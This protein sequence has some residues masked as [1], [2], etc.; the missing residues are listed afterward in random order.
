MW[1]WW[2]RITVVLWCEP[3]L[4]HLRRP[5]LVVSAITTQTPTSVPE[6][7]VA[8]GNHIDAWNETGFYFHLWEKSSESDGRVGE[9]TEEMSPQVFTDRQRGWKG[10]SNCWKMEMKGEED[11]DKV[12]C[13]TVWRMNHLHPRSTETCPHLSRKIWR[14]MT[15]ISTDL[16]VNAQSERLKIM[17]EFY[18][19]RMTQPEKKRKVNV[20]KD[21]E[22]GRK[23]RG[24]KW[25]QLKEKSKERKKCS[26]TITNIEIKM[27]LKENKWLK[28]QCFRG[29]E[30]KRGW[31][32]KIK[33]TKEEQRSCSQHAAS[34]LLLGDFY[35]ET[36]SERWLPRDFYFDTRSQRCW[37][38]NPCSVCWT[39]SQQVSSDSEQHC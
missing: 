5:K 29:D 8:V 14:T 10:K 35:F 27:Q 30:T 25:G 34:S 39:N 17:K 32:T 22:E 16:K 20:I 12:W 18:N 4:F 13:T 33:P 2:I 1:F 6:H 31:H 26:Q 9:N 15:I 19:H 11:E 24:N 37:W 3:P 28:V 21:K 7:T 23:R 38:I 36:R